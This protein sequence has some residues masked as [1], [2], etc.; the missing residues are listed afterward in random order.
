MEFY[1]CWFLHL[2]KGGKCL[3]RKPG[4][5]LFSLLLLNNYFTV[6]KVAIF[7]SLLL[8]K[9]LGLFNVKITDNIKS[10]NCCNIRE[11]LAFDLWRIYVFFLQIFL[12]VYLRVYRWNVIGFSFI[13]SRVHIQ[14]LNLVKG[15]IF[16][17]RFIC[18]F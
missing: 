12:L 10:C 7:F 3:Q 4:R 15:R 11:N 1:L 17:A 13:K 6:K 5:I 14:H 18:I 9:T 16:R 8:N 2:K